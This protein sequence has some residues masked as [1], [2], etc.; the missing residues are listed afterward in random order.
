MPKESHL[1]RLLA[2]DQISLI[3]AH[4][5]LGALAHQ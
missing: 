1:G 2:N 4:S 5:K 3:D